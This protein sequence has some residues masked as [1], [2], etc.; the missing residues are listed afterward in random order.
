[1]PDESLPHDPHRLVEGRRDIRAQTLDERDSSA[2][3]AAGQS[4]SADEIVERPEERAPSI[5]SS[6]PLQPP[7]SVALY[8]DGEALIIV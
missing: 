1:M 2:P 3:V 7:R 5:R 6:A 4:V 8:I